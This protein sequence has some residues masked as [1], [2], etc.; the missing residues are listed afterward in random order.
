MRTHGCAETTVDLEDC[1]LVED[2]RVINLL[3]LVIRHDLFRSG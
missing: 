3:K 1:E 2:L